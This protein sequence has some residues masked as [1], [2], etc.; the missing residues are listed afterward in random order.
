MAHDQR[1]VPSYELSICQLAEQHLYEPATSKEVNLAIRSSVQTHA[2]L[3]RHPGGWNLSTTCDDYSFHP[4]ITTFPDPAHKAYA[5]GN[6]MIEKGLGWDGHI[7]GYVPRIGGYVEWG[8]NIL[9]YHSS[10]LRGEGENTD[11]IYGAIYCSLGEYEVSD[12]LLRSLLERWDPSTNTFLFAS[13]ER[14]VTLLD[15]LL[16]SGL[17]LIGDPYEEYV[18]SVDDLELS[19]PMFPNFFSRLLGEFYQLEREHGSVTFQIWCDHFHNKREHTLSFTSRREQYLYVA[20][21]VALWLCCYVVIGEG[22]YIRPGVLLMA[23]WIVSG[24]KI[25]LAPPALCSLYYSLRRISTHPV[26]PSYEKRI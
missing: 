13:G 5:L 26:G 3:T 11:Y 14:T 2:D 16:L 21:F 19:K 22:P 24:R 12:Q 25:S 4:F 8:V 23:S 15:M 6:M 20:A 9:N 7:I 18:P 1:P 10:C 17:P